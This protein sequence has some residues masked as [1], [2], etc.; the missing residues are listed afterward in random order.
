VNWSII[1]DEPAAGISI[2]LVAPN[3]DSGNLLFQEAVSIRPDDTAT[4]LYD[5]LNSIQERELGAAV[6]RAVAGDPGIRQSGQATYGCAR[7][8]DDGEIDWGQPTNVIDRL[9]RALTP[10]FPGAF[11]HL[12]TQRLVILRA[13]PLFDPP[14][15]T[16]RVPGRVVGRS[17]AEGWV[18]VLTGDGVLR[19]FD[20][21]PAASSNSIPA[22]SLIRSTRT[23][24]GLS[25]LD[26][27]RRIAALEKQFE[28]RK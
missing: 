18:D 14:V 12:E 20:I 27:L 25:H 8:P 3:L 19:V 6:I 21:V 15:Y 2:H 4:S 22:A 1:N 28:E 7:G 5:R 9:I 16:G 11:T 23:T 26:L 10:P 13:A 24:L 17:R